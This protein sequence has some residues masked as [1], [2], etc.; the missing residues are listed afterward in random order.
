MTAVAY[1]HSAIALDPNKGTHSHNYYNSV[2]IVVH[3]E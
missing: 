3:E 2:F 1:Y